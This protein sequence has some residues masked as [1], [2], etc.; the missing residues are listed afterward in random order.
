MRV[1]VTNNGPANG[2]AL[3]PLWG[4]FH[5]GS[6]DSYNGGLSTQPGLERIA[7]D[8]NTTPISDDFNNG[9]TYIDN[10]GMSPVSA[11]VASGQAGSERVDGTIGGAP[12]LPGQ[13]ASDTFSI[14][15]GAN[16]FFSYVSMVIP[17]SDYYVANGNPLAHDVSSLFSGGGPIVIPVGLLNTVNDAGTEINDFATSAANPLFGLPGGQLGVPN[18]GADENGV[19]A[20]VNGDPFANFLN[21][22]QNDLSQLNFNNSN[23]YP[24]GIATITITAIPEP[25]SAI[26]TLGLTGLALIRRRK[27]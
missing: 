24:N 2:V 13:T 14:T 23:L 26:V 17:S 25:S 12:I 9:L 8:G 18:T 27:S 6:F 15:N 5:D 16:Q 7:E 11:T 4:G 22:P 1:E 19:N 3:T 20:N 21:I 10:S